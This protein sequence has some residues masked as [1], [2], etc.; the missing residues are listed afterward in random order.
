M[1]DGRAMAVFTLDHAM[2]GGTELSKRFC[3]AVLAII[4][5]LIFH[6][7][8]LPVFLTGFPI[9]AIH[10]TPPLDSEILWHE[11]HPSD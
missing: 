5:P 1:I 3:M 10:I 2:G 7:E 8:F 11:Q 9:P 6:L 4:S